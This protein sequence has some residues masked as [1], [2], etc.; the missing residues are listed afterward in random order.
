VNYIYFYPLYERL[1]FTGVYLVQTFFNKNK[2][3]CTQ[4]VLKPLCLC[5]LQR[6]ALKHSCLRKRKN[7]S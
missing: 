5:F 6:N 1:A 7:N 2:T 4:I 3:P